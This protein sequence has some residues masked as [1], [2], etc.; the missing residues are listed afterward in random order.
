MRK[1]YETPSL[2]M[3]MLSYDILCESKPDP[4]QGTV[5]PEGD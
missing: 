1:V 2:E 3:V 4:D 5:D